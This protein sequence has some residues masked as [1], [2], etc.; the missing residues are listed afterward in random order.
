MS[1]LR[2]GL[3]VHEGHYVQFDK[4]DAMI[5]VMEVREASVGDV[6]RGYEM[7]PKEALE[8]QSKLIRLGY[9]YSPHYVL[10]S[11]NNHAKPSFFSR[12]H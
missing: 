4:N 10:V 12:G 2:L 6:E 8:F 5:N 11:S 3:F 9:E 7:K 1:K